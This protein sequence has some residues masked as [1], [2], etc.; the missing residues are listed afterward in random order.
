MFVDS[1]YWYAIH[2]H[3]HA[4]SSNI[5]QPNTAESRK[6]FDLTN[7]GHRDSVDTPS[8]SRRSHWRGVVSSSTW[9]VHRIKYEF[10]EVMHKHT[11][12]LNVDGV[13]HGINLFDSIE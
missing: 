5:F 2:E 11:F 6:N 10:N 8:S 7:D 12:P 9:T 1:V 4:I 3:L 13:R